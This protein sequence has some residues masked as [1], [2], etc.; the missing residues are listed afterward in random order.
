MR[1]A[2][3]WEETPVGLGDR[4]GSGGERTVSYYR[5]GRGKGTSLIGPLSVRYQGMTGSRRPGHLELETRL[6]GHWGWGDA[7]PAPLAR[8]R[9]S[10]IPPTMASASI[11][12]LFRRGIGGDST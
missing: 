5:P 3:L 6:P 12:E 1:Q 11:E 10:E 7:A 2:G 8:G 4:S 9:G